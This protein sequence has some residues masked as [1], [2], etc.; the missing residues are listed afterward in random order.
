MAWDPDCPR[1][2]PD[3][4]EGASVSVSQFE[5]ESKNSSFS[6]SEHF[7]LC[8]IDYFKMLLFFVIFNNIYL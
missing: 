4:P 1:F 3:L 2:R 6:D 5:N 8:K 7:K